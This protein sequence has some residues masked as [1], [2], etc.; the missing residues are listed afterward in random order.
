MRQLIFA[1]AKESE[2][3]YDSR[4]PPKGRLSSVYRRDVSE[5][6]THRATDVLTG[7]LGLA[8]P[9]ASG[10]PANKPQYVYIM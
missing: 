10:R 2:N 6:D 1:V 3:Y 7:S 9:V 4:L 5:I 8:W